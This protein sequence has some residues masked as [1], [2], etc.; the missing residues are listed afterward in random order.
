MDWEF[1]GDFGLLI[2]FLTAKVRLLFIPH[3]SYFIHIIC[4][5]FSTHP[6]QC[7]CSFS[8]FSLYFKNTFSWFAAPHE[9]KL[10]TPSGWSFC[11]HSPGFVPEMTVLGIS[12]PSD[13]MQ[14]QELKN[15]QLLS[16]TSWFNNLISW[17]FGRVWYE[18]HCDIM[19]DNVLNHLKKT[20]KFKMMNF[21]VN[22]VWEK[23][24]PGS[25]TLLK[26]YR[27]EQIQDWMHSVLTHPRRVLRSGQL[28]RTNKHTNT[29]IYGCYY[30]HMCIQTCALSSLSLT[31][32][33]T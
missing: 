23:L 16:H 11:A 12:A 5:S 14:W 32:T 20:K 6:T 9:Q 25:K 27:F 7:W 2:W 19:T 1:I 17:T 31:H 18:H 4:D 30:P 24:K 21:N 26:E 8:Y 3:Y 29:P 22:C 10:L 15:L 13:I 28:H 33:R